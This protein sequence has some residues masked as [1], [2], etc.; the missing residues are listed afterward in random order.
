MEPVSTVMGKMGIKRLEQIPKKIG[1]YFVKNN[2]C[3]DQTVEQ[4]LELQKTYTKEGNYK[5]LGEI[6]S[7]IIGL[8]PDDLQLNLRQQGADLLLGTELFKTLPPESILKIAEVSKFKVLPKESIVF[9]KGDDGDTFC[10]VISG[11]AE[12]YLTADDGSHVTLATFG[13]GEGF[14]DM[15]LLTGEPR[16][17]SIKSNQTTSLLIIHKQSFEKVLAENNSLA[18]A[19]VQILA[20]RLNSGNLSLVKS[21]ANEKAYKRFVAEHSISQSNRLIG[22]SKQLQKILAQIGNAT[23]DDLPILLNGEAGAGKR[24]VARL[25]HVGRQHNEESPLLSMDA[26]AILGKSSQDDSINDEMTEIAQESFLFGHVQG[27]VSTKGSSRL[28]LLSVCESGTILIEHIEKLHKDVQ[29]KLLD[30]IKNGIFSKI[31]SQV[32]FQSAARIIASTSIDLDLLVQQ[33]EFDGALL[34]ELSRH[35]IFVP[36]LRKRKKDIK[37]LVNEFIALYGKQSGKHISGIDLE[38][39]SALMNYNWPGNVEELSNVIRRAVNLAAQD[40][41]MPEDI[42]LGVGPKAS[43]FTYDLLKF[44]SVQRFFNSNN[45]VIACRWLVA[46]SLLSVVLFGFFGSQL[47]ENNLALIMTWGIWEPLVILSTLALSRI[48]CSICPAGAMH[49]V[50]SDSSFSLKK[51]V[52]VF[53]R[54]NGYY[55]GAAGFGVIVWAEVASGMVFSPKATAI[56]ILAIIAPP[57]ILGLIFQRRVWC[58]Y[59]CP[60]G[61][62]VGVISCCSV[63]ELRA[64]YGVCNNECTTHNCYLGSG[65]QSGCPM[66]ETPFSL[67][68]NINC[69]LCGKCIRTC[70]NQ[71]P[72]LNVRLPGQE[73]WK[74]VKPIR[75]IVIFLPV[76]IAVQLLRGFDEAG[77]LHWLDGVAGS[78]ILMALGVVVMA[79][80]NYHLIK[81]IGKN[82]F[83]EMVVEEKRGWQFLGHGL[84]VL[85]A[86][87]EMAFQLGRLL[88]QAGHMLPALGNQFGMDLDALS[89]TPSDATVIFYQF[90]FLVLGVFFSLMLLKKL[91]A[92]YCQKDHSRMSFWRLPFILLALV[93]GWLFFISG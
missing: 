7:E 35:H 46:F 30:F 31:G 66:Y 73:L 79:L 18:M 67:S 91:I 78:S 74:N 50:I 44:G 6:I 82:V 59:L 87:I 1:H 36:P 71:S 85:I 14:G 13:P 22:R 10:L 55:L 62:F 16:T 5:P 3:N 92:T 54:K 69:I 42:F 4:A 68:N 37:P 56:L 70:P 90:V 51:R 11:I 20:D 72:H 27:S 49:S 58:R 81:L 24:E 40:Q 53:I 38:A 15:A 33:G 86:F 64:N 43:R 48:W 17:A 23:Q 83:S 77:L 9:E 89:I 80:I 26:K 8:C 88:R 61:S 21:A 12:A 60:L 52:P 19:F 76:I 65:G 75:A 34:K 93:H 32:Q 2:L 28:G 29:A 84:I 39:Y 57:I 47:A 45:L 41:I 63:V 25:V